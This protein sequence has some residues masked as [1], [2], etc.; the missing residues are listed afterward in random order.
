VLAT[1]YLF[2][3]VAPLVFVL[4]VTIAKEALDDYKRFKRDKEANS[5][6][7][8]KLTPLGLVPIPSSE[9]QVGD[10]IQVEINQRVPADMVVLRTTEKSGASFIRT[11]QL[12]GETDWKL[13][14][15]VSS[16]QKL[17]SDDSLV[18]MRA[19]VYI[20]KPKKDIYKCVPPFEL[21]SLGDH[22]ISLD[23]LF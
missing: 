4:S 5:Q 20:E 22:L 15:A 16:S 10:Y 18:A 2:T 19:S 21:Y 11:D 23:F 12:D 9:I 7:Y 1:G 13:R 17:P 6:I 8:Q 3:Y 14:R